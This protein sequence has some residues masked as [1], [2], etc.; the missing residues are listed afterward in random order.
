MNTGDLHRYTVDGVGRLYTDGEDIWLPSVS[1]VLGMRE[2]PAALK[3][4]K[5]RQDDYEAV[6]S[7]KQN[8]GTLIHEAMLSQ[9]TPTDPD[10]G[11]PLKRI[12]GDDERNSAQELW[13]NDNYERYYDDEQWALDTWEIIRTVSSFDSVIDVETFVT[14]TDVGYAGQFDLLYQD[15]SA[16]ETVLADIKTSK[17]CYEKHLLQLTAYKRAVPLSIDRMEVIRVNP[18]QKDLEV[19]DNTE[20]EKDESELFTEFCRLRGELEQQKLH[21]IIDTIQSSSTDE[22]GVLREEM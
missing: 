10:T 9:I 4:W 16:G 6:M 8:R 7:F 19:F 15:E 17:A 12:W 2:T 3:R 20:W 21:T 5:E 18:D 22:E 14:N 13:A 11:D 1:T